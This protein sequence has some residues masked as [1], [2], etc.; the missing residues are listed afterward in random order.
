MKKKWIIGLLTAVVLILFA[1]SY[2]QLEYNMSLLNLFVEE[3]W[4]TAEERA[5][6]NAHGDLIY[7]SD[8]NSPPLR[9]VNEKTGQYEGLVIDYIAALSMELGVNIQTK[10]MVWN[11]ALIAIDQ[12]D[13]DLCDM[14][15]SKERAK[16]F[17]FSE[18]VYYQRGAILV[19]G[20]SNLIMDQADLEGK[21]IAAI[22]GDYVFEHLKENYHQVDTVPTKDLRSAIHALQN[23]QVD[24]VLG[25]ES[26]IS[27][28][29]AHENLSEK[30]V[31]LSSY[32][33]E[34]EAFLGVDKEN[35]K[36]LK[37]LNKAIYR[38][39]R[40]DTM[41]RIH[42]KW[43]AGQ[44]LITKNRNTEKYLLIIQF[45]LVVAGMSA[46][47]LY[48]WN[49]Q[50]K[51]EVK[52][53]TEA[54]SLSNHEL[55][56][57]FNEYKLAEKRMLQSHK[58]AA[59]GQL[60]AGIAHEIRTP[61]GIIRNASFIVKRENQKMI[62]S[63]EPLLK[64]QTDNTVTKQLEVIEQSV[65]RANRIIDNLLN[66]SRISDDRIS[67]IN[68]KAFVEDLWKL[69]KNAWRS[70]NIHFR[71][72]GED[73][74]QQAVYVESLKHVLLNLFSNAVDAMPDGGELFVRLETDMV[75][76]SVVMS[77]SDTGH[78]MSEKTIAQLFDPFFTT[79]D[80]SKG[81]GLG[82]YIVYNEIQ[83]MG[84]QITVESKLE[85]GS[86]FAIILPRQMV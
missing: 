40:K 56:K 12:G 7:G 43:F 84:A 21:K 15:A 3:S 79:K 62:K 42:D 74:L 61:L 5:Y 50:L 34:R 39:N 80:S 41:E 31:L 75:A 47:A 13:T 48:Y 86:T 10:P 77:V 67:E 16:R 73:Q 18:P 81:T 76:D 24:A 44:P 20:G 28:Y 30:Y 46:V 54:L 60:A 69:N 63:S 83:K 25:D 32:L 51:R 26:V 27:Y 82:L 14:Y 59:V 6:L 8:Q 57:A 66:F 23:N 19:V 78:G 70:Q 4:L 1:N 65:D 52:R 2:Y 49:W 33:Y 58:M 9:Y 71:L 53:Q 35:T 85:Q 22:Q 64:A 72:E 17:L 68:L 45:I 55:E 11:E 37:I 36:L 29:L 38:L